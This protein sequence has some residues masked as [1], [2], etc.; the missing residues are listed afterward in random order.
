MHVFWRNDAANADLCS[1][2]VFDSIYETLGDDSR[3]D[4]HSSP[5][6]EAAIHVTKILNPTL[7]HGQRHDRI[8]LIACQR[9][10]SP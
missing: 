4:I 3:D 1:R 6:I 10:R 5:I 8:H 2:F 7:S 9:Q